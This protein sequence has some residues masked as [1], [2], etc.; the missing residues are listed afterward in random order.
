M[1]FL[2]IGRF[3]LSEVALELLTN[4][5][6]RLEALRNSLPFHVLLDVP[7]LPELLL[8]LISVNLHAGISGV[9]LTLDLEPALEL[10]SEQLQVEIWSLV[11]GKR[12]FELS[13]LLVA[14][15]CL[16]KKNALCNVRSELEQAEEA[17]VDA[18]W[19]SLLVE[20]ADICG[21][22]TGL[23]HEGVCSD[24]VFEQK[25]RVADFERVLLLEALD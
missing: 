21:S 17:T 23:L 4:E 9:S 12:S 8:F 22:A 16:L 25:L 2:C 7:L 15:R 11:L 10:L 5:L 19:I 1:Q 6:E 13:A 14:A 3:I 20:C 24:H 18:E